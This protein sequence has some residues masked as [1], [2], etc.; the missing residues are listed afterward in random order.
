[1]L[2]LAAYGAT[3]LLTTV[4]LGVPEARRVIDRLRRR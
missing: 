3:Y 1:V 2:V 4:A